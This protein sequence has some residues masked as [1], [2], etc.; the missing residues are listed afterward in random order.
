METILVTVSVLSTLLV[1]GIVL[2]IVIVFNKLKDKVDVSIYKNDTQDREIKEID[3]IHEI[4]E[5][6]RSL[7]NRV[8]NLEKELWDTYDRNIDKTE[9]DIDEI[10]RLLDSRCDRLYDQIKSIEKQKGN[11]KQ[12][13]T[14]D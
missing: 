1:V 13:L 4:S 10:K 2:G 12:L 8:D 14:E 7:N 5:N 11:N 9:K 6:N 3:L